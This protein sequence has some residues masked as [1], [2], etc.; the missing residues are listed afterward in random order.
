MEPKVLVGSPTSFH[1][2]YCL[3]LFLDG[4]KSLTYKNFDFIMV[5]NSKDDKYFNKIKS[6]GIPVIKGPYNEFPVMSISKSRNLIINKALKECYDYVLFIDSDTI[7][8][9][10]VI[11]RLLSHKKKIVCGICFSRMKIP[12]EGVK[13]I[14][15]VFRVINEHIKD[16]D[17]LPSMVPL[18]QIE[19][20]HPQLMRVVSCGAGS[21]IIHKSILQEV[22]FKEDLKQCED[23]H[24]CIELYKKKIQLYCDTS[25]ICKHMILNR[26]Y[27]WMKGQLVKREELE[28]QL[29]RDKN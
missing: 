19:V 7:P 21:M 24:F 6:K 22:K 27:V 28:K 10:D 14:P 18:N 15:D 4:I 1:K 11:Q 9:S 8:P 29:K 16:Q 17:G 5:E 2:E 3:D 23:R 25:V 26:P 12:G 20:S 13:L